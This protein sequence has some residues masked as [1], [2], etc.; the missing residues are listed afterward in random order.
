MRAPRPLHSSRPPWKS[1]RR[2]IWPIAHWFFVRVLRSFRIFHVYLL[3]ACSAVLLSLALVPT[4][5]RRPH[6]R[7]DIGK[8]V[9]SFAEDLPRAGK[10][11]SGPIECQLSTLSLQQTYNK[12]RSKFLE[13][14]K[15][16]VGNSSE[17]NEECPSVDGTSSHTRD[18]F[19][20]RPKLAFKSTKRL[21]TYLLQI[22]EP[23]II[24]KRNKKRLWRKHASPTH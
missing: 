13:K 9:S 12:K 18:R 7:W 21:E 22:F 23:P 10:K 15:A 17:I 5:G 19:R 20:K 16:S 2:Q 6:K 4:L 11:R 3:A 24:T 1:R 8:I 14:W